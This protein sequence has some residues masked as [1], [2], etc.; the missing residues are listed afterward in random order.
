[1]RA[2]LSRGACTDSNCSGSGANFGCGSF[3]RFRLR[4]DPQTKV[5][6]DAAVQSNGCGYMLAAADVLVESVRGCNLQELRGL[7][8]ES[9]AVRSE[10]VLVAFPVNRVACREACIDAL[11]SA[12]EEFRSVQ[13]E[14]FRGEKPLVC[15]CF[16]VT[17][18][19]IEELIA[20]ESVE[21]VDEVAR[22]CNAGSGCGSCRI[23][24]Q[25]ILDSL[26]EV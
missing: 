22:A 7:D 9:L 5:V 17:E 4:I 26:L 19:R 18:E 12:L 2:A 6:E 11:A 24:I 3:V 14:E 21:S 20:A 25:E 16:G 23:V 8:R 1:M 10:N 13:L 15:T